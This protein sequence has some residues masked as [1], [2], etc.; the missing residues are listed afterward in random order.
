MPLA[1]INRRK[2]FSDD[3]LLIWITERIFATD[4]ERWLRRA[5]CAAMRSGA[6]PG[7]MAGGGGGCSRAAAAWWTA[8][9]CFRCHN[10]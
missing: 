1:L 2:V 8:G 7:T 5:K 4:L 3:T 10:Q 9:D 6:A